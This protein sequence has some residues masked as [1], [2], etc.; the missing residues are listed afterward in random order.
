MN[1]DIDFKA[2]LFVSPKKICISINDEIDFNQIYYSEISSIQNQELL[3]NYS[4]DDFLHDNIFKIEKKINKF[5]KSIY[6][7]IDYEN[8][9]SL[10]ISIKEDNYD[11]VINKKVLTHLLN[12]AKNHCKKS[13]TEN[14]IIHILI[15]N[16]KVDGKDFLKF[17]E[18]LECKN[19]SIDIQFIC[20]PNLKIKEL[21]KILKK[22]QITVNQI[23][24]ANYVKDYFRDNNQDIFFLSDRIIRGCNENEVKIVNKTVENK[25]FFERFF[26]FFS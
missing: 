6:V 20:F 25:G 26:N 21:E 14:E 15:T 7:I 23:I 5:I 11:N 8:F 17:P 16:Y 4:L 3:E 24:C 1:E 13:L 18:N 2:Y 9:F 10:E 22:Y 19:F 12:E